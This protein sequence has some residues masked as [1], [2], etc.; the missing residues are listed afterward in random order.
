MIKV[1]VIIPVYNTE[2][3]LKQCLDS[4]ITQTL[5]EMEIICVDDGSV[6]NCP[7]ILDEYA[8]R[9][10][11]I[12]VI[13][14]VNG[15]VVSARRTGESVARGQ[16]IGYVD[17]D[18]WIDKEMFERM[19]TCAVKHGAELV[20]SGYWLE[21]DYTSECLDGVDGGLYVGEKMQMLRE[22]TIYCMCR[23][24]TG[25][26]AP[27][28][29]KLF[30]ANLYKRVTVPVP[31]DITM[32]EDKLHILTCIL[33]CKSAYVMKESYYHYRINRSSATRTGNP[34]YL[35]CVD[36][37][38]QYFRTLY[39]H[40]AFTE[41]MRQQAELYIMDM[42]LV[43]VNSRL[44]FTTR[45]LLWID[46]YWMEHISAGSRVVLY[47]AGEAGRKYRTQL[48]ARGEHRYVGCIDFEYYRI[49]DEVLDVQPPE[50]LHDMAYDYVV[51]TIKN[52][53]KADEVRNRLEKL[54]VEKYSLLWFE[55]KELF[56]R[57]AEAEGILTEKTP[58]GEC[59]MEES[60][61]YDT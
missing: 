37:V 52:Q 29:C 9:Y 61:D 23:K 35:L 53:A 54:G 16:Y 57:Y 24:D 31:E 10:S 42:L 26:R 7:Q 5:Q 38:Y 32:S 30:S 14:K 60:K 48:L 45:N 27:Q 59:R 44:G 40:T 8:A 15:G 19:Y 2:T 17:S 11:G 49:R 50:A 21:G 34:S 22:N 33:E 47:G 20:S 3:Y 39:R 58:K 56:W 6:D 28:P 12:K 18:D 41:R 43:A 25:L 4:V 13:H 46:P 36:K 51:I 1:S 55:Q